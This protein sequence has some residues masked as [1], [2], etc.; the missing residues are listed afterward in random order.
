MSTGRRREGQGGGEPRKLLSVFVSLLGAVL[1]CYTGN[2]IDIDI[3]DREEGG[4][5]SFFQNVLT[6]PVKTKGLVNLPDF[7]PNCCK[8]AFASSSSSF[9]VIFH[10]YFFFFFFLLRAIGAETTSVAAFAAAARMSCLASN[11]HHNKTFLLLLNTS[12]PSAPRPNASKPPGLTPTSRPPPPP[13]GGN[14]GINVKIPGICGVAAGVNG[15]RTL[16]SYLHLNNR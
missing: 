16:R 15:Y 7:L 4:G 10:R 9:F 2:C 8:N 1:Q 6:G 12:R 13:C 11:K 5:L 3:C 14:T